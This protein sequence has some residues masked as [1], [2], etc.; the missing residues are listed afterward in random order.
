MKYTIEQFRKALYAVLDTVRM[1]KVYDR[2]LFDYGYYGEG[3]T[4]KRLKGCL[5][6]YNHICSLGNNRYAEGAEYK[7]RLNNREITA[8]INTLKT[9]Q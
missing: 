8:I 3:V 1:N 7:Y 9:S 6:Y 2:V 4:L 5:F